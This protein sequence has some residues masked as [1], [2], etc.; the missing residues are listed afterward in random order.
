MALRDQYERCPRVERINPCFQVQNGV[1][2][3]A[4]AGEFALTPMR[5]EARFRVVIDCK[6][7]LVNVYLCS[8][9]RLSDDAWYTLK[10]AHIFGIS[11][12][13]HHSIQPLPSRV[14]GRM[15]VDL[16]DVCHEFVTLS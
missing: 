3:R 4:V 15:I 12:S 5:K 10:L 13:I 16:S 6:T 11:S 7:H 14:M 2:K 8:N 9:Q 1:D